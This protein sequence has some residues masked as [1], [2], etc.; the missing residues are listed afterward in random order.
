MRGLEREETN[1]KQ[2]ACVDIALGIGGAMLTMYSGGM[3]TIDGNLSFFF[4]LDQAVGGMNAITAINAG[5]FDPSVE[6]KPMKGLLKFQAGHKYG[7]A[8]GVIYD[9]ASVLVAFRGARDNLKTLMYPA[10]TKQVNQYIKQLETA[11][12]TGI[13]GKELNAILSF[14]VNGFGGTLG[15]VGL[16]KSAT[17]N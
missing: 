9:I 12:S 17:G 2:M 5:I 16:I 14:F 3:R 15:T 7:K 10:Q 11:K 8:S 6:Y 13:S 4:A 1:A